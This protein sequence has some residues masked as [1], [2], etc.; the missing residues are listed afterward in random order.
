MK[1]VYAVIM[2]GGGGTRLWPLSR[3]TQPKHLLPLLG[4]E[5]LFYSTVDRLRGFL[6]P[7]RILVVTTAD[8]FDILRS[9]AL[10]IPDKNFLLEP[11][12]RG[13][14]GVVGLAASVLAQH[15]PQAV[16]C[17]LPSDHYIGNPEAFLSALRTA[18]AVAEDGYLVTLGIPP[19]F[20]STGYGYIQR[21]ELLPGA[22]PQPVYRARRFVEKPDE[23]R[24]RQMLDDGEHFWNSGIFVWRVDSI[25][26]EIKRQ[27]PE[28]Y[29]VLEQIQG[30]WGT[31]EQTSILPEVWRLAPIQ[32]I[33]Y[34]VMEHAE[35]I[36]LVPAS[37]LDWNDVG[38]WDSLFLVLEADEQG[39][40]V[41]NVEFFSLD[42]YR[43]LVYANERK[44]IA[45]IGIEDL[46]VVDTGDALLLC[47]RGQS[48]QVRKVIE[49]LKQ[50]E[51]QEYL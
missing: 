37:G 45:A 25:L 30:I 27:M 33:D 12:P 6:P 24:A 32:T 4:A 3:R 21:A 38:S 43:T 7:E 36:A 19:T 31:A 49:W 51:R 34:G 13:T 9:Q 41:R 5:T 15:N 48:Q 8:Q 16:M 23:V 20:P 42:S 50:G 44:L 1:E 46:I 47:R 11:E 26:Q 39:N 40:L 29:Q 2:A 10:S 17:V 18:V 35:R 14:A 22:F 28:L